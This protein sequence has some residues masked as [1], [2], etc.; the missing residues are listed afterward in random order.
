MT[1]ENFKGE[2]IFYLIEPTEKNLSLYEKWSSLPNNTEV[3]FSDQVSKCYICE[4]KEG[5]TIFLPTG[6]IHAV[7]TPQDSI[8]FGGNFI[9]SYNI[10]LQLK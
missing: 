9:T 10:P 3:F 2:K 5:N 6:Y 1:H 8:D 4:I 7:Y